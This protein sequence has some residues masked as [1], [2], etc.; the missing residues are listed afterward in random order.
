MKLLFFAGITILS[1]SCKKNDTGEPGRPSEPIRTVPGQLTGAATKVS[2]GANGGSLAMP[3]KYISIQVPAGAVDANTEFSIQEVEPNAIVGTGRLFRIL[4][5]NIAL[6]KPVEITFHYTDADI[7]GGNE[8]YLHP[9]F[10]DNDGLWHKVTDCTLDKAGKTL[11]VATTHFSDWSVFREV[12]IHS[13]KPEIGANEEIDLEAFVLDEYKENDQSEDG[14]LFGSALKPEQIVEWKIVY[15]GGSISGGKNPKIKYKAPDTDSKME[16]M[17]EVT[18]K[19]VVKRSDPKRPGNGGLFI[20]RRTLTILPE[21]YVIWTIGGQ[22]YTG[23]FFSLGVFDGQSIM[24]ATAGNSAIA[25]HTS[26]TV[27][28]KYSFG[29]LD[30]PK[31]SSFNGTYNFDT[32]ESEY[33]ECETYKK[34]FGEGSIVFEIFGEGGGGMV[35]GSFEGTVY[36]LRDCEVTARHVMGAFRIRRTY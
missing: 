25:F 34:V 36:L 9:C 27:L 15:G 20:V 8:D 26:G 4:P 2:I 23:M 10:Q 13:P 14:L 6:K 24:T 16:V 17:I 19:N 35:Q 28:G 31:K 12:S 22:K 32:Y 5:E 3:D 33:T 18:V 1:V 29:K 21:E 11:K 30:E 7:A